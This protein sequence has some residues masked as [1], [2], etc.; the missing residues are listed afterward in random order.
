MAPH[1]VSVQTLEVLPDTSHTVLA[2]EVKEGFVIAPI[3]TQSKSM[4]AVYTVYTVISPYI[5]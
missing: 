5:I 2:K 4:H 1:T 3:I